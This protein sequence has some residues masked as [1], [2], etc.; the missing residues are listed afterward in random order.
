[1]EEAQGPV[2]CAYNYVVTAQKP[3]SVSH[4]VVGNFTGAEDL[5]LIIT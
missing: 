3:T 5:N 1:M 2:G 4:S